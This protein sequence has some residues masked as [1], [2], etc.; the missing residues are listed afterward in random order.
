M[1]TRWLGYSLLVSGFVFLPPPSARTDGND[2]N[3]FRAT[4]S[5]SNEVPAISTL[6][7]GDFRAWLTGPETLSYRLRYSGLAPS[8]LFAHIHFGQHDVNGGVSAF[9][10]GGSTKPPCP[11][12]SGEVTGTIVPADVIGPAGQGIAAGEFAELLK[13]IRRGDT[14]ANVHTTPF[15][16]GEI[17]G[18]IKDHD[19]D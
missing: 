12:L 5:G 9:L 18:Q 19:D 2:D 17:R 1:K 16:T 15:P 7:R 14:Y 11:N 6:A 13:Q 3:R 8:T 10:C 4:L